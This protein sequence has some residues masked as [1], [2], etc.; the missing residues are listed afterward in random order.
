MISRLPRKDERVF[1]VPFDTAGKVPDHTRV[2]KKRR[3][4][5]YL[6]ITGTTQTLEIKILCRTFQ[7]EVQVFTGS[8]SDLHIVSKGNVG[9][10]FLY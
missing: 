3:L 6:H 8:F 10:G 4:G 9:W 7:A 1:K 2:N 5:R